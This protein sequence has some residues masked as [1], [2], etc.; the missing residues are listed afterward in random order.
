MK[1]FWAKLSSWERF[2]IKEGLLNEILHRFQRL[3]RLYRNQPE[4][5]TK[6]ADL[7]I[8][9][10]FTE[11]E[12]IGNISRMEYPR[13]MRNIHPCFCVLVL[14]IEFYCDSHGSIKVRQ[15]ILSWKFWSKNERKKFRYFDKGFCKYKKKHRI[16]HPGGICQVYVE[17]QKCGN[18]ECCQ[19][20]PK[21]SRLYTVKSLCNGEEGGMGILQ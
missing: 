13:I 16:L 18:K 3:L 4:F 15:E 14:T 12:N 5:A 11:P 19:R 7:K 2:H 6:Y 10:L 21:L 8:R 9:K 17:T 20:H 1:G